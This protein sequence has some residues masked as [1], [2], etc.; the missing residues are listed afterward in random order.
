VFEEGIGFATREEGIEGTAKDL[1]GA[2][3]LLLQ[4][5]MMLAATALHSLSSAVMMI[6]LSVVLGASEESVLA[7]D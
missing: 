1:H 6:V 7:N 2:L 3:P 4:V 5:D